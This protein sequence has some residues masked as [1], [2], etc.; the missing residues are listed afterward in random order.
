MP[1]SRSSP[2][3]CGVVSLLCTHTCPCSLHCRL[4]SGKHQGPPSEHS[5]PTGLYQPGHNA[6]DRVAR[7]GKQ[8]LLQHVKWRYHMTPLLTGCWEVPGLL[9][10]YRADLAV[11]AALCPLLQALK[12]CELKF[13]NTA[14]GAHPRSGES[15][16]LRSS[17][18]QCTRH[19]IVHRTWCGSS[20]H[21]T[22]CQLP[23]VTTQMLC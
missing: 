8:K 17:H 14:S 19:A 11:A 1:D 10:T 13:L 7:P 5:G 4:S 15:G 22:P 16:Y 2:D 12:L 23:R 9:R 20:T 18:L 21:A 3:G 6:K